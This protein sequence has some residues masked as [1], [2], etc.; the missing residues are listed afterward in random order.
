MTTAKPAYTASLSFSDGSAGT[1]FPVY[2]G[3][4]GPDV[5]DIR[6]LYANTGKFT[7]DPGFMSTSTSH[8]HHLTTTTR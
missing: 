3:T 6:K 2:K 5:I 7:F 8:T 1:E 4:T